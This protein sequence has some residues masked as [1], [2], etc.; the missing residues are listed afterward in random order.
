VSRAA[1]Q[2]ARDSASLYRRAVAEELLDE[3]RMLL[4]RLNRAGVLTVDVPADQLSAGVV[5]AYLRLKAQGRL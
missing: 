3:R 2:A 1:G 5:N 4:D